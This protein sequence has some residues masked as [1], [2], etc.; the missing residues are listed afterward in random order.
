M[1]PLARYSS[2]Y[3]SLISPDSETIANE[4]VL[5]GH[6]LSSDFRRLE[7][8]KI[9]KSIINFQFQELTYSVQSFLIICSS[10]IQ[11]LTNDLSS[12]WVEE[13]RWKTLEQAN[14]AHQALH[15]LLA[16]FFPPSKSMSNVLC[17]IRV[18]TLSCVYSHFRNYWTLRI[19]LYRT[20]ERGKLDLRVIPH[21]RCTPRPEVC[22]ARC[23]WRRYLRL[24]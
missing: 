4:L 2:S 18:T 24:F 23:T 11:L 15:S 20:C 6:G 7:E 17:T 9:S 16:T 14:L 3:S 19:H 1:L 22:K 13:V 5:V 21:P 8:M 12:P 10:L